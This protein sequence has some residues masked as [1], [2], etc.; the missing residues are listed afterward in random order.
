MDGFHS[1]RARLFRLYTDTGI[2]FNF[3]LD[4][5]AFG[6]AIARM[7]VCDQSTIPEE[8]RIEVYGPGRQ[9]VDIYTAVWS[10]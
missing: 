1:I 5:A 7:A 9:A 3:V 6:S 4:R 10:W 2:C 8:A